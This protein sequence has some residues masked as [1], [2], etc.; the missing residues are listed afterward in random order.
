MLSYDHR[1]GRSGKHACGPR[2]A[3]GLVRPEPSIRVVSASNRPLT[4]ATPAWHPFAAAGLLVV[5]LIAALILPAVAAPS[6]QL[7]PPDPTATV[8]PV[9]PAIVPY[10]VTCTCDADLF[11]CSSFPFW[12]AAQACF[13]Q[14]RIEVGFD[15]HGLDEDGDGVA[16]EL[17]PE[18]PSPFTLPALP[19]PTP[20]PTVDAAATLTAT[21]A[22]TAS[23]P[24]SGAP[25]ITVPVPSGAVV[26]QLPAYAGAGTP[27]AAPTPPP[28]I[29]VTGTIVRLSVSALVVL[30]AAGAIAWLRRRARSSGPG[31]TPP[32]A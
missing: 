21:N 6:P 27:D 16:C 13:N 1:L 18:G 28:T 26:T 15:I 3:A 17:A 5:S 29:A 30:V 7:T 14:C 25:A 31:G 8:T 4:Y 24:L 9:A 2:S 11:A 32:T 23:V 12:S 19:T 10:A 20:A 22:L